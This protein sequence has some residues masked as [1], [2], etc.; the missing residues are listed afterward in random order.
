MSS[1][2]RAKFEEH[3]KTIDIYTIEIDKLT[4]CLEQEPDTDNRL[5]I[6]AKITSYEGAII[7]QYWF[8]N[9]LLPF[10]KPKTK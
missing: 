5:V 4:E 1:D 3:K 8:M 9:Q 2:V 10:A 7:A 6:S